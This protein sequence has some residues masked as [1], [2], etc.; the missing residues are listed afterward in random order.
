VQSPFPCID[1]DN[2]FQLVQHLIL[3]SFGGPVPEEASERTSCPAA[4]QLISE[5]VHNWGAL[6]R[7]LGESFLCAFFSLVFHLASSFRVGFILMACAHPRAMEYMSLC[8]SRS[9]LSAA[10]THKKQRYNSPP[11]LAPR[12][13][14]NNVFDGLTK[15]HKLSDDTTRPTSVNRCPFRTEN[16]P[17][18]GGWKREKHPPAGG[19]S[20]FTGL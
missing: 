17:L 4:R 3:R 16:K 1:V 20:F 9:L 8:Y 19:V 5:R 11:R 18:W 2:I 13:Q 14:Q 6:A 7:S 15:K 10:R 12:A